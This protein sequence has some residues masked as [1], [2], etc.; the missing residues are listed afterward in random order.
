MDREKG[1]LPVLLPDLEGELLTDIIDQM[2]GIILQG[3]AILL[4]RNTVRIP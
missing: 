1:V 2:D 4:Q 3:G